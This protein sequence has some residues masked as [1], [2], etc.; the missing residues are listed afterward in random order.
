L[1]LITASPC[2]A[3]LQQCV[4]PGKTLRPSP[5][6]TEFVSPLAHLPNLEG[7]LT[8]SQSCPL[9]HWRGRW[10]S[11]SLKR[12]S[13]RLRLS[14]S[15]NVSRSGFLLPRKPSVTS[16]SLQLYGLVRRR[17]GRS[18]AESI[19]CEHEKCPART[20]SAMSCCLCCLLLLLRSCLLP[21]IRYCIHFDPTLLRYCHWIAARSIC[22]RELVGSRRYASFRLFPH[23]KTRTQL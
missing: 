11:D 17:H 3:H 4:H 21:L 19:S 8:L 2:W 10:A 12:D 5:G 9:A 16:G 13:T 14:A 22:P 20:S 6:H 7:C 23:F 18:P 15:L 1:P